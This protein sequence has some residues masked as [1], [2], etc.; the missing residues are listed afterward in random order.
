MIQ[1]LFETEGITDMEGGDLLACV[2]I[3]KHDRLCVSVKQ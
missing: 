2:V 3:V 1:K